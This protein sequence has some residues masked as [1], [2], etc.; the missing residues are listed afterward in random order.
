[1]QKT[2]S[3][4]PVVGLPGQEV[5]VKTAVYTPLNYLSDGTVAVGTFAFEAESPVGTGAA[6]PFASKKGEAVIGL[7]ERTF[8]GCLNADEN[9]SLVFKKG[10]GLTVA[11]RGDYYVAATGEATV[12]QNVL[13]DKTTGAV[14]YGEASGN[15]I[16]TGWVV[17]TPATAE[18]DIIIVSCR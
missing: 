15:N 13:V 9:G 8:T 4:N 17:K 10:A 18:G 1:M 2:V 6:F 16:A 5:A 11:V 3:L 14:S 7:V 12:G